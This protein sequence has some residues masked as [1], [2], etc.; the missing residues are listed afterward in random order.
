MEESRIAEWDDDL[1]YS[2]CVDPFA[3]VALTAREEGR[4]AGLRD[5][6]LDGLILGRTKGWEIGLELGY[7]GS[8]AAGILGGLERSAPSGVGDQR[9]R[10]RTSHRTERC[11]ALARELV[12]LVEE[13]PEPEELLGEG[14]VDTHGD[15]DDRGPADSAEESIESPAADVSAGRSSDSSDTPSGGPPAGDA[16]S[17]DRF[18]VTDHLQRI[19]S[20]FKLFCVL[21]R[22]DRPYDLKSVLE[23]GGRGGE[24][25]GVRQDG[26][27]EAARRNVPIAEA[28]ESDW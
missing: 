24:G 9:G 26:P 16:A 23:R 11:L 10:Q 18:D 22:T 19:R 13:F 20:K 5:G 2:E 1:L 12:E 3:K 25:R 7:V 4:A 14:S 17:S 15:A 28:A 21:L 8:F 6:H 27:E